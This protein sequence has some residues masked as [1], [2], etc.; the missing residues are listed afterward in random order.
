MS[1]QRSVSHLHRRLPAVL[2]ASLVLTACGSVLCDRDSDA[3]GTYEIVSDCTGVLREGTVTIGASNNVDIALPIPLGDDEASSCPT[4][5][6][7]G[8]EELGLPTTVKVNGKKKFSLK[9]TAGNSEPL[10][11]TS[12]SFGDENVLFC[13]SEKEDLVCMAFVSEP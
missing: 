9:G 12:D 13:R 6:I 11:C 7:T 8:A 1:L 4:T 5:I 3:D 10:N 2:A